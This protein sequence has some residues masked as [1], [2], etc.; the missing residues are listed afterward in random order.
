MITLEICTGVVS[1]LWWLQMLCCLFRLY[2]QQ[3]C[4]ACL[5]LA[6]CSLFSVWPRLFGK[7]CL[8][9]G[10][11]FVVVHLVIG[12]SVPLSLWNLM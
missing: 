6:Q 11:I 9:F 1:E 12:N 10:W 8:T 3:F 2:V 4:I 5:A 7:P